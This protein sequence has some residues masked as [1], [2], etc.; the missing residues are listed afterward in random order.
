MVNNNEG[1]GKKMYSNDSSN[2]K[3]KMIEIEETNYIIK[4][5]TYVT[6]NYM[7][8]GVYNNLIL[9]IK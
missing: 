3:Y 4:L 8:Y 6:C 1:Y 2:L 7:I 5:K 9:R